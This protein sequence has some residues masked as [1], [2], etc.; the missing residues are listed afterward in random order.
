SAFFLPHRPFA[1][2]GGPGT[3]LAWVSRMAARIPRGLATVSTPGGAH[4]SFGE[5]DPTRVEELT[6]V[7][8]VR[9]GDLALAARAGDPSTDRRQVPRAAPA[10]LAGRYHLERPLGEGGL[11]T[12]HL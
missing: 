3:P 2:A 11:G 7:R 9:P 8:A 12:V 1:P 4:P 10:P 6:Q 5:E